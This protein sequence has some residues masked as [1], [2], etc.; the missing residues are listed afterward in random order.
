MSKQPPM[1]KSR[2]RQPAAD[3]SAHKPEG[4]DDVRGENGH[5]LQR[6]LSFVAR[7]V[8]ALALRGIQTARERASG[9]KFAP[10]R[11]EGIAAAM[12]SEDAHSGTSLC[13]GVV[14]AAARNGVRQ[15]G[16]DRLPVVAQ[17]AAGDFAIRGKFDGHAPIN[18]H[19]T[20]FPIADGLSRHAEDGAELGSTPYGIGGAIKWVSLHFAIVHAPFRK[21]T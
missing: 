14:F 7:L 10:D 20:L 9:D 6:R 12:E 21:S 18:R 19:T 16:P 2:T 11:G 17:I 1:M 3:A 8:Q 15:L 4:S 5:G 13:A